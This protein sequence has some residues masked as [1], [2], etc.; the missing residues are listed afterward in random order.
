MDRRAK[1]ECQAERTRI[2]RSITGEKDLSLVI[3]A[4]SIRNEDR[5]KI[6]R[7]GN[8]DEISYTRKVK[9][10][11][12]KLGEIGRYSNLNKIPIGQC[13]EP[14]AANKVL[15][16]RHHT[17][18]GIE[19]LSFSH[20]FRPRTKNIIGGKTLGK[21]TKYAYCENCKKVFNI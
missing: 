6:G 8:P 1:T 13:A 10:A 21:I 14:H 5:C 7:N 16:N 18:M 11:L 9:L 15:Q 17:T 12:E 2:V 3:V 4:C 19:D 20:A